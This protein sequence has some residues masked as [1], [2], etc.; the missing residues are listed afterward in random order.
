MRQGQVSLVR[1]G[2]HV[3]HPLWEKI[4]AEEAGGPAHRHPPGPGSPGRCLWMARCLWPGHPGQGSIGEPQ[5]RAQPS[6]PSLAGGCSTYCLFCIANGCASYYIIC[7]SVL[8]QALVT[9]QKF[10]EASCI[11]SRQLGVPPVPHSISHS[12]LS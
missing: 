10:L 5:A 9:C 8:H 7:Y 12:V 1:H 6:L 3:P 2:N 11:S 4:L